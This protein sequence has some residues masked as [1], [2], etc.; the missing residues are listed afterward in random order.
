MKQLL[1]MAC[2]WGFV[3]VAG[4]DDSR[5]RLAPTSL[6]I[7]RQIGPLAY[8]G[9]P[10][11]FGDAALGTGYR[12]NAPGMALTFYAYDAGLADIPDGAESVPVCEEFEH[13]KSDVA[14]AGYGHTLHKGDQ[15]VRLSPPR[16]QPLAREAAFEFEIE[17]HPALSFL[18]FTG[19]ERSFIKVRFTA[20]AQ[21]RDDVPELRREVLDALGNAIGPRPAPAKAAADENSIDVAFGDAGDAGEDEMTAGLLYAGFLGAIAEKSPQE[22]PV[23]GGEFVPDFATEMA[24]YQGL[25]SMRDPKDR[26]R[27]L[28]RLAAI[29][30]AGFLDEYLWMDAHREEWGTTPPEGLEVGAYQGWRK[31][32]LKKFKRPR[33]ARVVVNHPRPLALEPVDR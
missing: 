25:I 32:N 22:G 4:A 14:K 9:E 24:V 13:A 5:L 17:N 1:W 27:L 15:L 23:C 26:N 16:E 29:D 6:E 33:F 19:I 8:R 10:D 3:G 11:T 21:L 31:K 20:D 18:W 30:G 12:F 2:A 7:P 28:D